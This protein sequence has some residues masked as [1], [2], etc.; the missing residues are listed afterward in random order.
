MKQY[1]AGK[2]RSYDTDPTI[3]SARAFEKS[4]AEKETEEGVTE[5]CCYKEECWAHYVQ[6]AEGSCYGKSE[7]IDEDY[8]DEE[9]NDH[10]WVH[11]CEGHANR[12]GPYI[13]L[14]PR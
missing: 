5:Y 14:K 6:D 7:V 8:D 1:G 10:T 9:G 4:V 11:A 13:P 3:K 12:F 2:Y